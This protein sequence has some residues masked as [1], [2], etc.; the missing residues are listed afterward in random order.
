MRVAAW[1]KEL[2]ELI[3]P[4]P[5]LC[6]LCQ[7][8]ALPDGLPVCQECVNKLALSPH[9]LRLSRYCG[10]ALSYY[11]DYLQQLL[12][13]VKYENCYEIAVALGEVLGLVAKEQVE[14]QSIDYFVPV[15]LHY[16]RLEE[17]GFNQTE[18]LV[19][20][21]NRVWPH[22][23]YEVMRSK[24][25]V[26]QSELNPEERMRNLQ[27]AFVITD[28]RPIHGKHLL[29]IDDIFTTGATFYSLA[30]LIDH[31]RGLP[32]GLFLGHS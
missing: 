6:P 1:I 14:L 10:L 13:Q 8:K 23:T 28:Q 5:L 22:P 3:L 25:T 31:Q 4:M 12:Y 7:T 32:I 15:P 26:P 27:S 2:R 20:G 17:R 21:M 11:R 19:V 9:S 16:K 30:D 24:F 29:I 18:A